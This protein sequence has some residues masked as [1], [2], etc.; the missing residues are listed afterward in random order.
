ML[1]LYCVG[2]EFEPV[3]WTASEFEGAAADYSFL[4][5]REFTAV[6]ECAEGDLFGWDEGSI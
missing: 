4:F 2:L 5:L 3:I 1:V 6:K